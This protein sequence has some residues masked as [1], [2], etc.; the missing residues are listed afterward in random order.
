MANAIYNSFKKTVNNN[1]NWETD[2]IK[3]MLVTSSYILDI[4]THDFI[5]DITGE[6]VGAG[7]TAGGQA[8]ANKAITVDLANDISKYSADNSVWTTSSITAAGAIVYKD[9]G[10]EASS[11]LICFIDFGQDKI[12]DGGDFSIQWN[13]DGVFKIT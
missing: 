10:V 1:V 8:L 6:A 5:D 4:D 12:S 9:T 13:V 7:Y 3:V 2:T 11:P